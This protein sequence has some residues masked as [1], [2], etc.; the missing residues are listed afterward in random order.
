MKRAACLMILLGLLLCACDLQVQQTTAPVTAATDHRHTL[1]E[2]P[3]KA[4]GVLADGNYRYYKCTVPGCGALFKDFTGKTQVSWEDVV[5]P[6]AGYESYRYHAYDGSSFQVEKLTRISNG[7]PC[8]GTA[9]WEDTLV[10]CKHSGYCYLYTLPKGEYVAEFPLGSFDDSDRPTQN[11]CNQMMFGPAKFHEN[12]PFP[13]LYVTTGYSNDHDPSG[14]YY[15][16]C[17]VERIRQDENGKWYAEIVQT[18]EFNDAS[19][20]PDEDINGT[21]SKMYKDGKF[22]YTSGNGYDASA[23]YQKIGY[24]WPHFYVDMAPTDETADKLFIWSTRFRASEYWEKESKKQY[25]FS[26]Y[27]ADNS[28]IITE[29]S[30][31]R[32]PASESD[33]AYGATVTLYPKDIRHQ[34]QTAF[35]TYAFQGGTMY[36]G[37]IYHSFGDAQ[38]HIKH[39]DTIVVW[40][41]AKEAITATLPLHQTA[42]GSLEPECVCIYNGDLA[43]S[44]YNMDKNNMAV[45]L[46]IFGY[47]ADQQDPAHPFCMVCGQA[48]QP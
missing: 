44:T 22:L 1:A 45:D 39:R 2:V 8:Q 21:L 36:H 4:P 11:H 7:H 10:I 26:G 37:K 24:G 31:P 47:V 3:A 35:T 29:F 16:K 6:A 34:F 9:I 40:D 5:V 32:L 38:Q 14:A 15:A 23:G 19:N 33:P 27:E 48:M 28:Y 20:I 30:L 18:I 43:L 42:V 13:L 46:F 25:G 17:S 41:I 12:D